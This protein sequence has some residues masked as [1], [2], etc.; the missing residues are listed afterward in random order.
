MYAFTLFDV[1][2]DRNEMS[3]LVKDPQYAQHMSILMNYFNMEKN[4][5]KTRRISD[6]ISTTDP[7]RP[8]GGA[9]W[10]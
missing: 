4:M 8:G 3:D 6:H 10:D 2:N 9:D 1:E 5:E 7:N